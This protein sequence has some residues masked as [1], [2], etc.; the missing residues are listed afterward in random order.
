MSEEKK[1]YEPFDSGGPIPPH[2]RAHRSRA[3]PL[4][5]DRRPRG[6]HGVEH[7]QRQ[8]RPG[9]AQEGPSRYLP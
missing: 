4:S 8:R 9:A 7:R 3:S 2:R 5:G 6:P 1:T